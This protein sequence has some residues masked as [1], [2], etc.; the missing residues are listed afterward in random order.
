MSPGGTDSGTSPTQGGSQMSR[1]RAEKYIS[2]TTFRRDGRGVAT[3][4]WF[5]EDGDHI[6]AFTGAQT[7]KAKRIRHNPHVMVAP[8]TIRGTIT[9]PRW[10]GTV[11]FLPDSEHERVMGLIRAKYRVTKFLLDIIVGTIR[12][13]ARKPQ[14]HSVYL[15]ISFGAETT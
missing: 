13:I 14:T 5:A 12:R 10:A 1:L 2:L 4:V 15:Q 9:G 6:V 7:G 3:P 8:C 11:E